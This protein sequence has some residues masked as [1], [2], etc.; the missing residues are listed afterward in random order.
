M[1][2]ANLDFVAVESDFVAVLTSGT[3]QKWVPHGRK[4]LIQAMK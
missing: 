2:V 3:P 1:F 4:Q